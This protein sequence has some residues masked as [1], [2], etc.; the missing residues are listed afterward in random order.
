VTP[1]RP[2]AGEREGL[3]V[4]V[5]AGNYPYAAREW[6]GIFTERCVEILRDVCGHVEVLVPRPYVPAALSRLHRRWDV[7]RQIAARETRN[8]VEIA[9]PG[10]LQLPSLGNFRWVDRSRFCT[11]R[12]LVQRM[13][14]RA[15]FDAVLAF[16]L[17]SAG[18]LAWRIG[19][20]LSRP[21]AGWA[22]G[23]DVRTEPGTP[24]G[25]AVAETLRRLDLVLYQ[26][27]EL[28]SVA[29][30]L[31]G[32]EGSRLSGGRHVVLP[33]GIPAPPE[34][35]RGKCRRE[36]RAA[37]GVSNEDIVVLYQGRFLRSK[38]V[39]ELLAAFA[40]AAAAD[41][42]LNCVCIG[43]SPGFDESAEVR[44]LIDADA[45][46]SSRVRLLP[47]CEPSQVW[48]NLCGADLFAFPSHREGMP[49]S[50]LEA[51]AMGVPAVA[52]A[53]PPV[54]EIDGGEGAV[55]L[56]EPL[57]ER[58]LADAIQALA[59]APEERERLARV[60]RARVLHGFMV[61]RNVAAAADLAAR[62]RR[63]PAD[64]PDRRKNEV[65]MTEKSEEQEIL[66]R[67]RSQMVSHALRRAGRGRFRRVVD[68]GCGDGT[69][70]RRVARD[71][72][73]V[74]A[75]GV[76]LQVQDTSS[77]GFELRRLNLFEFVAEEPF[78]LV[79]SNQVFEHIHEPWLA[80]YFAVLK[81]SCGFGGAIVIS[82][83]NRWRA[84]N[85]VRLMTLRRPYMMQANPG[86][87]PEKHLGHHRECSYRELRRILRQHFEPEGW[88]IRI[89]RSLPRDEGSRPR[90]WGRLLIYVGLFPLWRPFF[91]SAS[92]DHYAVIERLPVVL[93]KPVGAVT[94][95]RRLGT[96]RAGRS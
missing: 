39:F 71:V 52:F 8:G 29:A 18:G 4:L 65:G 28:K 88:R 34:L 42:R 47:A 35:D 5:V 43:A 13:H 26:S 38:G 2:A 75:V 1:N 68:L 74:E 16:D 32:E 95:G 6:T 79:V 36:A 58:G 21:V 86:I 14:R 73:A 57:D 80:R 48:R 50:L 69:V 3:R 93:R 12:G 31:L 27:E 83:P 56:V 44:A 20:L 91:V 22:L 24:T 25:R 19:Q 15:H 17:L 90:W 53:I 40:A 63:A 87:P 59:A 9:R 70:L 72:G 66:A 81:A 96:V 82:T 67:Y 49:N 64:S 76:D 54:R 78:D 89:V 41:R 33:H 37:W 7:Y 55:R 61:R 77:N 94:D 62:L 60:G 92:Q 45:R 51:M 10:Y 84:L 30:R 11:C 85:L 46:L 23:S